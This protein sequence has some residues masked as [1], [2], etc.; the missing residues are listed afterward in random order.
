MPLFFTRDKPIRTGII[1]INSIYRIVKYK[2]DRLTISDR[3][4]R[5]LVKESIQLT[6]SK[7]GRNNTKEGK[8]DG[9]ERVV[10]HRRAFR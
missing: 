10:H 9:R 5:I 3:Y 6:G 1:I 7:Q 8:K 4:D 2:S